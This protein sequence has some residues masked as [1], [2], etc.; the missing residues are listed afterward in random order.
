MRSPVTHGIGAACV[1][2]WLYECLLEPTARVTLLDTWGLT[3]AYLATAPSAREAV[4][5]L[6]SLFLHDSAF[7][8][9]A[10]LLVLSLVGPRAERALGPGAFAAFFLVSGAIGGL[11]RAITEPGVIVPV[12]GA[13]A[14]VGGI[15]LACLFAL[16]SARR[17]ERW[18][19]PGLPGARSGG[20]VSA[21]PR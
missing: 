21:V 8:L 4:T 15:A 5:L 7:M 11:A 13:E 1:A 18:H 2:M 16:V 20:T 10:N 9:V 6:T 3:P 12:V 14:G 17:T 19:G